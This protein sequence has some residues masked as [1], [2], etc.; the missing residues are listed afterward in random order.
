[1]KECK[2]RAERMRNE[3]ERETYKWYCFVYNLFTPKE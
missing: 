2:K 3:V 1:M